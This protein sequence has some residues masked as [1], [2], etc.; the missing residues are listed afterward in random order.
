MAWLLLAFLVGTLLIAHTAQQAWLAGMLPSVPVLLRMLAKSPL[1]V[2]ICVGIPLIVL[3]ALGLR[4]FAVTRFLGQ[5]FV[6]IACG[7][8]LGAFRYG[9]LFTQMQK[10]QAVHYQHLQVRIIEDPRASAFGS[11]VVAQVRLGDLQGIRL[12]LTSNDVIALE[13]G[14]EC[15]LAGV[16]RAVVP[17]AK[18]LFLFNQGVAATMGLASSEQPPSW[19]KGSLGALLRLRAR[20]GRLIRSTPTRFPVGDETRGLLAAITLGDKRGIAG[21]EFQNA[22]KRTGLIHLL[23]VSGAYLALLAGLCYFVLKRFGLNRRRASLVVL[24]VAALYTLMTGCELATV[25]ALGMLCCAFIA[26]MMRRR[27]DALS[28]LSLSVLVMIFF[29]PL[30]AASV[31]V[32]LSLASVTG[33]VLFGGYFSRWLRCL[34]PASGKLI[35][36]GF[37]ITLAAM[38]ATLPFAAGV[39]GMISV[40]SPGANLLLAPLVSIMLVFGLLG[41]LSFW[42]R[43]VAQVC[44]RAAL[45]VGVIFERLNGWLAQQ[46]WAALPLTAFPASALVA[47]VLCVVLLWALWPRPTRKRARSIGALALASLLLVSATPLAPHSAQLARGIVVL[48]VGQGDAL[49]VRDGQHAGLIDT[50]PSPTALKD[51]L[52]RQ[53]ITQLD[54]VLFTH[55]HADHAGGAAALDRSFH[56]TR[57]YV[58]QGAQSSSVL[59]AISVRLAV[60]LTGMLSGQSFMLG[61]LQITAIWPRTAVRDPDANESCLTTLIT[62]KLPPAQDPV[63]TDTLL[64]SGDAEEPSVR[65]AVMSAGIRHVD[66]LKVPHHGSTISLSDALLDR[67]TP[68]EAVISCGLNN[69]Y[70]H[71]KPVTL[72]FLEKHHILYKRTDLDGPILIPF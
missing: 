34:L 7:M 60:P 51:Q 70:G 36:Q 24:L 57:L 64:T 26:L 16:P 42:L 28:A 65:A 61:S 3:A 2:V 44:F 50:G 39:F 41:A 71:P 4:R 8:I 30:L 43:P 22:L 52:Y 49:L 6:M 13:R 33:I 23:T 68:E 35:A 12:Q 18:R 62:D 56:I 40:V 55:G 53:R 1:A 17:D 54:F 19:Q 15:L 67:L 47:Y 45:A 69:R 29:D 59:Q 9:G 31:S 72:Q 14:Q 11:S 46:S 25:R 48:D 58:A 32:Q 10:L 63:P 27:S 21:S 38:L 20:I 37:G 5:I 66:V